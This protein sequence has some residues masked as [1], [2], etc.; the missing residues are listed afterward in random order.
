MKQFTVICTRDEYE[1]VAQILKGWGYE[2]L[3]SIWVLDEDCVITTYDGCYM[4]FCLTNLSNNN[5]IYTLE[6]LRGMSNPNT[7]PQ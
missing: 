3:G 7:E 4:T 6:E 2:S 5:P 1:E